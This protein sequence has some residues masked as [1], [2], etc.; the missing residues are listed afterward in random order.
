L[1][2]QLRMGRS[3]QAAEAG[4]WSGPD[5]SPDGKR[6]AVHRHEG[7]GGDLWLFPAGQQTPSRF[8]FDA[9][10]DNSSPIWSPDGSR[11]AFAS[12]RNGKPGL[13]VKASDNTRGEELL[14]ELDAPAV[15][16]SWSGDRIVYWTRSPKTGGDLWILP[17]TGDRKPIPFLQGRA[18]ERTPQVSPDGRWIAYSSNETGRS[19]IYVQPFPEGPGR[20]QVSVNGGVFPR[21]R[22]DGRELYFLNIISIGSVMASSVRVSGATIERD[23]PH[24]LFQSIYVNDTHGG[25][26]HHAYATLD[27]ER[28]LIPEFESV[29]AAFGRGGRGGAATAV[30]AV[31]QEVTADRH[32]AS[33][34][35][36]SSAPMV[37][38]LDWTALLQPRSR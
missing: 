15:P 24:S 28:F 11:I 32:A 33:S 14:I 13:Y 17:V 30:S 25:L 8:T 7:D 1:R 3:E 2:W 27:G 4:A 22:K 18:D 26:Q 37:V 19:E 38:V 6:I 34:L 36:Q 20:I 12:R 16:M 9:S 23:V 21:W 31:L 5:L 10:Q 29:A 35:A